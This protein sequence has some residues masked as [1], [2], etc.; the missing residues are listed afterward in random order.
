MGTPF[1]ADA[2]TVT[3]GPSQREWLASLYQSN[4]PAV[5]RLC[6]SVLKNPEDAADASQE[7][8]LVAARS[9]ERTA[10]DA[11]ARAWLLTVARNHC[12]D[13]LRRRQRLGQAL[14]TLGGGSGGDPDLETSIVD[15]DF[16]DGVL[17]KLST[18]ERQALWQ[19]VVEHRPLA[20]IAGRL[21]LS[22][23]AAAQAVHRAR[24]HAVEVAGRVA[25]VVGVYQL[26]RAA[27]RVPAITTKLISRT[28]PAGDASLAAAHRL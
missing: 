16:V 27:K 7:V 24:R 28:A 12:V 20:D 8:F 23:M 9:L 1:A 10:T 4:F 3:M 15:R 17:S 22:Y 19:S 13:L 14:V 2:P 25:I 18:R 11:R 26:G 6:S 21:R 5:L